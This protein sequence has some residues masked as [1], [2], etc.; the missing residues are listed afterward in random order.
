M[1]CEGRNPLKSWAKIVDCGDAPLTWLDNRAAIRTLDQAHRR[2]ANRPPADA[3][4]SHVPRIITLGGDHTTTLSALRGTH[5]NWGEVSVVHFDSHI[6]EFRPGT[7]AF[8]PRR[9]LNEILQT[10]GILKSL[11]RSP[12]IFSQVPSIS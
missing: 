11:V 3:S 8:N 2:T 9:M 10:R 1:Y 6:G 12:S 4:K 7:V 5:D